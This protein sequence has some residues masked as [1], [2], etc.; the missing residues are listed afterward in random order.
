MHRLGRSS[1]SRWLNGARDRKRRE[2]GKCQGRESYVEA[3]PETVALAKELQAEGLSY[4]TI[5]AAL[6]ELG[7]ATA[8]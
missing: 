6:A 3:M 8:Q 7:H 5:N 4:R 1:L 2:N